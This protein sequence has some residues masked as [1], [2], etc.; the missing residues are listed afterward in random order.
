MRRIDALEPGDWVEFVRN[1]GSPVFCRLA[2]LSVGRARFVFIVPPA[3][4]AFVIG[5]ELFAQGLH[6]GRAR[7]ITSGDLF[8]S[9]LSQVA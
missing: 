8:Q 6:A 7:I 3:R 1:D 9:A 5:E 2:W 4:M